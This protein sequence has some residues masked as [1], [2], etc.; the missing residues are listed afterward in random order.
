MPLAVAVTLATPAALVIALG[1]ESVAV[2]PDGGGVKVTSTPL[3]ALL[4][5]SRTVACNAEPKA[6]F[7]VVVCE[8]PPVARIEAGGPT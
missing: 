2:A 6:V 3:T 5:A 7:T 4:A 8:V 1:A